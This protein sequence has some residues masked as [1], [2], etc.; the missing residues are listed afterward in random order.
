MI[1]DVLSE[2]ASAALDGASAP[3][4]KTDAS[5]SQPVPAKTTH[6][7]QVY[8]SE[9]RQWIRRWDGWLVVSVCF[10]RKPCRV[11]CGTIGPT[12]WVAGHG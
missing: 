2:K 7:H 10:L 9:Y 8:L 1:C 4:L 6:F 3:K 12:H 11:Q 5:S